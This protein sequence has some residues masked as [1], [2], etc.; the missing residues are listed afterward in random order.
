MSPSAWKINQIL[1]ATLAFCTP[2]ILPIIL[3]FSAITRLNSTSLL[4]DGWSNK[5][6][7]IE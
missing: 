1:S 3:P 2:V 6:T 5:F 4:W 7:E